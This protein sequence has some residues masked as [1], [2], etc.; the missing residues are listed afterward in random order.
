M[1]LRQSRS[2]IVRAV[3]PV[4]GGAALIAAMGVMLWLVALTISSGNAETASVLTPGEWTVGRVDNLASIID[5][6]GPLLFQ[7]PAGT[8]SVGP[9]VVDHEGDDT[10]TGWRV[11]R[12]FP[13]DRVGTCPVGVSQTS[14]HLID[15]DGNEI[16]VTEL[17]S[18]DAG[19]V[20]RVDDD[21]TLVIDF[22][23]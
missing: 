22:S 1:P 7:Q 23:R 11:Y 14:K 13:A 5:D 12:A 10:T 21:T 3:L 8:E 6:T 18:V 9:I 19:V 20:P 17:A 15:C 4:L 2:P 16:D